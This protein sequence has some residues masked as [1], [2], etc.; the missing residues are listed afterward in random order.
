MTGHRRWPP[1]RIPA[2]GYEPA[3]CETCGHIFDPTVTSDIE[4]VTGL[5]QQCWGNQYR[6]DN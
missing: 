4:L 1:N 3:H 6:I 5:C 2:R